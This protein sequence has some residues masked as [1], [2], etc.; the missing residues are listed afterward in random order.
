MRR[1]PPALTVALLVGAAL[2]GGALAAFSQTAPPAPGR[3]QAGLSLPAITPPSPVFGQSPVDFFRALLKMTPKERETA[4]TGQPP[5]RMRGL[6][7]KVAEYEAL[8]VEERNVRLRLVSLRFYLPPL[9]RMSA[10]DR[11]PALAMVPPEDRPLVQER[12]RRWDRVAPALQTEFLANEAT[13]Q[14][15]LRL[16]Y[17]SAREKPALL[18]AL[19]EGVGPQVEGALATWNAYPP[20]RRRQIYDTFHRFFELSESEREKTLGSLGEAERRQMEASLQSF[21]ALPE[22]ERNRCIE[23]FRKFA[24]LSEAERAEFL[25]NVGRWKQMTAEERQTWRDLVEKLPAVP[26]LPPGMELTR[27]PPFPEPPMPR[28]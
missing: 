26:P 25:H 20:D 24:S 17:S 10:G 8:P 9:M 16:E 22:A 23:S 4:L 14:Y 19:R 6:L 28:P 12:L 21:A 27:L 1:T 11:S 5:E 18:K 2:L 15:F 13:V 3:P 7:A